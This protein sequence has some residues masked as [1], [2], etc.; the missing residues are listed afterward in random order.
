MNE[1]DLEKILGSKYIFK[2]VINNLSVNKLKQFEERKYLAHYD[3]SKDQVIK[4]FIEKLHQDINSK[5]RLAKIYQDLGLSCVLYFKQFRKKISENLLA[6]GNFVNI[7]SVLVQNEITTLSVADSLNEIYDKCPGK[8]VNELLKYLETKPCEVIQ[9]I[10][11]AFNGI[12]VNSWSLFIEDVKKIMANEY[13]FVQLPPFIPDKKVRMKDIITPIEIIHLKNSSLLS[14]ESEKC[15]ENYQKF[16]NL[17]HIKFKK[18]LIQGE[19][20]S[21]KTIQFRYLLYTYIN[22]Y[23]VT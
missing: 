1:K 8:S 23:L 12:V 18:I 16:Y 13:E 22:N 17:F 9:N 7:L 20:G 15:F 19:P 10:L 6:P 3:N 21:G 4:N 14:K 11:P 5:E 2:F